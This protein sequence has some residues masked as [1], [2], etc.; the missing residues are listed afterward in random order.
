MFNDIKSIRSWSLSKVT[1]VSLGGM[2]LMGGAM[3]STPSIAAAGTPSNSFTF[4]GAYSGTLKLSPS[5]LNCMSGKTYNGK[6][7][8]VT[9]SHMS[10][11]ISG[12]GSGPW[13]MSLYVPK[14]GTTKVAKADVKSLTDSSL[15]S[16]GFPII[17]F[18]ETSGTITDNGSK[19]TVNLSVEYHKVGGSYGKTSTVT[20]SWSC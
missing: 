4:K 19:G 5:T 3:L 15:Q 10:G 1:A 20:G 16:N 12:A 14:L 13:A 2:L 11:A 17:A 6:G 9:L 8:L 7:Y 18:D